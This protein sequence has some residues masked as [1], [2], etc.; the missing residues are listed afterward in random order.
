MKEPFISLI[1]PVYNIEHLIGKTI[2]SALEQTYT[3]WE[4]ILVDDGSPDHAGTI[5][6]EY[7]KKDDRIRVI[8]KQN[9]GLAAARNTGIEA[10]TGKYF[11]IFEGS[12]LLV[13]KETLAN[14]CKKLAEREVDIYFARLQDMQEKGW[15]VTDIQK[16][17]CVNGY[18][19]EGGKALFQKL[20]ENED[21]LALSSPVNKVF[22]TAFVK[23]NDLKFYPGI[24]HDDD[25]WLPRA[26]SLSK[27]SYFTNDIIYNALAWDGSFGG[28]V[29]DKSLCKKAVDKMFL[30]LHCCEDMDARCPGER[31]TLFLKSYFEYYFRIYQSGVLALNVIKDPD[32]QKQVCRAARQYREMFRYAWYCR[33]KNLRRLAFLKRFCGLDIATKLILRRYEKV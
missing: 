22:R 23:E 26:I 20:F 21:V 30:A 15:E 33:S 17:Y 4:M 13:S 12:D 25:E 5:C 28:A 16:E 1:T 2:E 11:L 8:H 3:D 18:F 19:D 14:I 32:Y 6:D 31:G 24:Y 27:T 10:C 9:E 29:S 7:A